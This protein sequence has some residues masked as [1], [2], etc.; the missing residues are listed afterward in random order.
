MN[1]QSA[2]GAQLRLYA[3]GHD[4]SAAQFAASAF[5]AGQG[6]FGLRPNKHGYEASSKAAKVR[7]DIR[8]S[9]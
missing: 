1:C 9:T 8:E 2:A 4:I 3:F 6:D 7:A 5:R